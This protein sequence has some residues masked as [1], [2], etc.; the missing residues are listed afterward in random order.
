MWPEPGTTDTRSPAFSSLW[1]PRWTFETYILS[2]VYHLA[3]RPGEEGT[4]FL[5]TWFWEPCSVLTP[6]SGPPQ[7]PT[8]TLCSGP[9]VPSPRGCPPRPT[10]AL[11]SLRRLECW[12]VAVIRTR[13][14]LLR[15]LLYAIFCCNEYYYTHILHM[16]KYISIGQKSTYVIYKT[17]I[18]IC[19]L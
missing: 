15:F 5:Y 1:V 12:T 8:L 13:F 6:C 2:Q 4:Q 19:I 17:G 9:A 18:P 7:S 16:W 3:N 11:W 10:Q 14:Y